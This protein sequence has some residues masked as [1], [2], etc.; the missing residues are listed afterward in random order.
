MHLMQNALLGVCQ[1]APDAECTAAAA[2]GGIDA[3]AAL[4][5]FQEQG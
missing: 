2:A 5:D 1:A 3:E 4:A